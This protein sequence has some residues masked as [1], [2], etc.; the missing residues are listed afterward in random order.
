M[1]EN[2]ESRESRKSD[3]VVTVMSSQKHL[4][5]HKLSFNDLSGY[6]SGCA[7]LFMS[8]NLSDCKHIYLARCI[9][10]YIIDF[11]TRRFDYTLMVGPLFPSSVQKKRDN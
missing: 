10:W 5:Q 6:V 7:C 11:D 1:D 4:F 9:C 8:A 3:K 2:D